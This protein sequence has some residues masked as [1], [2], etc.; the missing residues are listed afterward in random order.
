MTEEQWRMFTVLWFS[1]CHDGTGAA[2][3]Y[4]KIYDLIEADVIPQG[5]SIYL[6]GNGEPH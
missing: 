5:I 3:Q 6:F 1:W 2:V 4:R